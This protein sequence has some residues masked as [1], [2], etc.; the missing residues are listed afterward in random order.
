MWLVG[1][2]Q[3]TSF[4]MQKLLTDIEEI[5]SRECVMLRVFGWKM[6]VR[7]TI[8]VDYFSIISNLME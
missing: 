8:V 6:I 1:G 7:L 3:N 5:L 2:D 4:F